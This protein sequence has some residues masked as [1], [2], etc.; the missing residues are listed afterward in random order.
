M[1]YATYFITFSDYPIHYT[2]E[3]TYRHSPAGNIVTHSDTII[4]EKA[5]IWRLSKR[6]MQQF[7]L[8]RWQLTLNQ[9]Y[10]GQRE[11]EEYRIVIVT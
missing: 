10:T 4:V 2:I 9:R 11:R 6:H 3:Q 1:G 8:S 5:E 7:D